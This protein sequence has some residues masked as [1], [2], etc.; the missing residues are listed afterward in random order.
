ML[1]KSLFI[2]PL[3]VFLLSVFLTVSI[4][5]H[6][7]QTEKTIVKNEAVSEAQQIALTME[8]QLKERFMI[9]EIASW[10]VT[11]L[12]TWNY[13]AYRDAV[14][15]IHTRYA[16]YQ[17]INW[18]DSSGTIKW[19]YP[20]VNNRFLLNQD[21]HDF[22]CE[23]CRETFLKTENSGSLALTPVHKL[24]SGE[25]GF[26]VFIP[27]V[28]N[29]GVLYGFL[30]AVF[31]IGKIF[32]SIL[33]FDILNRV[34]IDVMDDSQ[35]FYRAFPTRGERQDAWI[36]SDSL[37][38]KD[39]T[40]YIRVY[41]FSA[42][43][44]KSAV[45]PQLVFLLIGLVLSAGLSAFVFLLLRQVQKYRLARDETL[46]AMSDLKES[47]RA[48]A[49][50]SELLQRIVKTV[51]SGLI[52]INEDMKILSANP[53]SLELIKHTEVCFD[54]DD[55]RDLMNC[56]NPSRIDR[57]CFCDILR[58]AAEKAINLRKPI[59]NQ[60]R[61]VIFPNYGRRNLRLSVVPLEDTE[62]A[63][64]VVV[65]DDITESYK[66]SRLRQFSTALAAG[67]TQ[68][69]TLE[70]FYGYIHTEMQKIIPSENCFISMFEADQLE[71]VFAFRS[72][73]PESDF[74]E[75]MMFDSISL[76]VKEG[77]RAVLL[78]RNDL[79]DLV[80]KGEI[81]GVEAMPKALLASPL[82]DNNTILG[83]VSLHD[84]DNDLSFF[85][86]DKDTLTYLAG[87][88]TTALKRK[89]VD[90]AITRGKKEWEHTFDTVPD[91]ITII[92]D[93]YKIKRINR[94]MSERFGLTP[95]DM[96]GKS[97]SEMIEGLEESPFFYPVIDTLSDNQEHVIEV[98]EERLGGYFLVTTSPLHDAN[99]KLVG[100]V[101]VARDI[102]ERKLA[103]EALKSSEQFNAD[104]INQASVGIVYVESDGSVAFINP[105][106]SKML[107]YT[108]D[109][110]VQVIGK[111][112]RNLPGIVGSD[113]GSE[114]QRV[115]TGAPVF[116]EDVEFK[117]SSGKTKYLTV[118]GAPHYHP[119]GEVLGAILMFADITENKELQMQLRQSQKMEAIGTLAGGIA[120]DFNN[121]LMAIIGNI[122]LARMSID[123]NS[124][125][126]KNLEIIQ[127][128]AER[129][130]EL[131][132]QLLAFGRR[133]MDKPQP[134]DVNAIV[135]DVILMHERTIDPRIKLSFA[136]EPDL[137][138]VTADS[139][140]IHQVV[141]NLVV[142]A[143]DAI[144]GK[145][146][147][148]VRTEN[149][150]FEEVTELSKLELP[151]NDY[152]TLTVS[153]TGTGIPPEVQARIFE[154]FF[155][156]KP[157]GKGTGLGLATV[158]SIVEGHHG[159]MEV[160]S[161]VGKG[162]TFLIYLPRVKD[163]IVEK[164]QKTQE[165]AEVSGG[166]ERIMVVDDEETIRDI[167][168]AMLSKAG[169]EVFSAD[170]GQ[171]ALD[172]FNAEN[173]RFNLIILDLSMPGMSGWETLAE[174]RKID[175]DVKVLISSGYDAS[176]TN[177]E[178]K[179][180]GAN[181]FI[182]KPYRMK[183]LLDS[184]REVLGA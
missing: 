184:I 5:R 173:G 42:L 65:I 159:Y 174:I 132:S 9:L 70:E 81:S 83:V 1:R 106:L 20:E 37:K 183:K 113:T 107:G 88:I 116:L 4:W 155:T 72:K 75:Q 111:P 10:L 158:Y 140:Q 179:K 87:E 98:H 125:A 135:D 162:T 180:E 32:E 121:L 36:I 178:V 144:P 39:V 80:S 57:P 166:S 7:Y 26:L 73:D 33:P 104:L 160:S 170:G 11:E 71:T 133:Q 105:T 16:G 67:V 120:H 3:I 138:V 168:K 128:S 19:V 82:R 46:H 103:D 74:E 97:Y 35:V 90:F 56:R 122:E 23:L 165:T 64:V 150:T 136:L 21:M 17:A 52:V 59:V 78:N 123:D 126:N 12:N 167:G 175:K 54:G 182:Q 85:P 47:D 77:N 62:D 171:E 131:T 91:L 24:V 154:P 86:M 156:T 96:I 118:H 6:N 38:F 66:S 58:E 95:Q 84:F 55:V 50:Q 92:D 152:V 27:L 108:V 163:Q 141:M 53:G 28:D 149:M 153:D 43:T 48:L 49:N 177:K 93:Q 115:L 164:V 119:E 41:P 127:S 63:Q 13:E 69:K 172:I 169:Y 161:M 22:E 148:I 102:T 79:E 94:S 30:T 137:W 181:G 14:E 99:N 114:L 124:A 31:N 100:V 25:A 109:L 129:G 147:I 139:G 45:K 89:M 176:G 29:Q 18:I 134:L 68:T 2:A 146:E 145:G 117:T 40:W 157:P 101:H 34:D 142:N 8:D 130:A 76:F 51:P 110:A 15:W 143:R 44:G 61:D 112:I 60:L 151:E